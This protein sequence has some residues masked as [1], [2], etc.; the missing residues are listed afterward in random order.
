MHVQRHTSGN[1]LKVILLSLFALFYHAWFLPQKQHVQAA[2]LHTLFWLMPMESF[3]SGSQHKPFRNWK[4]S[5]HQHQSSIFI[6]NNEPESTRNQNQWLLIQEQ[7]SAHATMC[8]FSKPL[9]TTT[10]EKEYKWLTSNLLKL[11]VQAPCDS[12]SVM[13][14]AAQSPC[15]YGMC[16]THHIFRQICF[17]WMSCTDSMELPLSLVHEITSKHLAKCGFPSH[18]TACSTSFKHTGWMYGPIQPHCGTG[19][20]CML[21]PKQCSTCRLSYPHLTWK[22]VIFQIV[23]LACKGVRNDYPCNH[24]GRVG[25]RSIVNISVSRILDSALPPICADPSLKEWIVSCMPFVSTIPRRNTL[26]CIAFRTKLRSLYLPLFSAS[27]PTITTTYLMG[28]DIFGLMEG[29][30]TLTVIWNVFVKRSVSNVTLPYHTIQHRTHMLSVHGVYCYVRYA[31]AWLKPSS[32]TNFGHLL[33]NRQHSFITFWS[34][35]KECLHTAAY[36]VNTSTTPDCM[37]LDVFVKF[38]CVQ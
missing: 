5:F 31:R 27:F 14:M 7:Q 20:S 26:P 16:V 18:V 35:K 13:P 29:E 17:P 23:M 3:E 25:V 12:R 33:Y 4:E 10:H 36:M 9:M 28:L 32:L 22:D 38:V 2:Y 11:N 37:C 8:P 6:S 24:H 34:T 15:C 1:L 19:G 21:V 30:N